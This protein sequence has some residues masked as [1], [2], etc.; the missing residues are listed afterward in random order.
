MTDGHTVSRRYYNLYPE[1]LDQLVR[2]ETDD[3]MISQTHPAFAANADMIHQ[4]TVVNTLGSSSEDLILDAAQK[5]RL[6]VALRKD[7]L[8]QPLEELKNGA[9]AVCTLTVEYRYP[10][11]TRTG[12]LAEAEYV[13]G[14]ARMGRGIL[15]R[16]QQHYFDRELS[17][18]SRAAA[19]AGRRPSDREQ[20]E[21]CEGG[22]CAPFQ[23]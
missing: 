2:L 4:V 3:E 5:E 17:K 8:S 16:R 15:P 18:Y 23:P 7:L 22:L 6:L 20:L 11:E 1:T 21:R 10:R 12:S 19:R 13:N 9:T 14:R